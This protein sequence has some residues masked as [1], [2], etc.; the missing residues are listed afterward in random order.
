MFR[1]TIIVCSYVF[2]YFFSIVS[3]AAEN[4]EQLGTQYIGNLTINNGRT[5]LAWVVKNL[6]SNDNAHSFKVSYTCKDGT[7]LKRDHRVTKT[8]IKGMYINNNVSYICSRNGG[9]SEYEIQH[10]LSSLNHSELIVCDDGRS[11][12]LSIKLLK[13]TI[14][15]RSTSRDVAITMTIK[16]REILRD[17]EGVIDPVPNLLDLFC[18]QANHD[19][20]WL[21]NFKKKV[22]TFCKVN[23]ESMLCEGEIIDNPSAS[24][25]RRG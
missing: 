11:V 17:M 15:V 6:N 25:G 9:L 21:P 7:K 18:G 8:G 22:R 2:F 5:G 1:K 24:N 14:L 19:P 23:P 16:K 13:N 20:S 10:D 4:Q 12:S 3:V